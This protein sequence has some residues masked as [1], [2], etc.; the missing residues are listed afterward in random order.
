ME[1]FLA[2]IDNCERQQVVADQ[3]RDGVAIWHLQFEDFT[4]LAYT[5]RLLERF[6]SDE[7]RRSL[8]LSFYTDE[9]GSKPHTVFVNA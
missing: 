4:W 8:L 1:P 3:L 7:L 6:D 2:G 5:I 9:D